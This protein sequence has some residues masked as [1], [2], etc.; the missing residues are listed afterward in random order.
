MTRPAPC[1]GVTG[2][3]DCRRSHA[4]DSE[5]VITLGC[6]FGHALWAHL[7]PTWNQDEEEELE[8]SWRRSNWGRKRLFTALKR[9]RHGVIPHRM[10][11]FYLKSLIDYNVISNNIL[12]PSLFYSVP[13]SIMTLS[14][15][16]EESLVRKLGW[17][18]S[19]K[20]QSNF[21]DLWECS[22]LLLR[23]KDSYLSVIG[24]FQPW[25]WTLLG[26]VPFLLWWSDSEGDFFYFIFFMKWIWLFL[27]WLKMCSLSI[28]NSRDILLLISSLL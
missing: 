4:G 24:R 28:S 14:R 6:L 2:W 25:L 15:Y 7:D 5:N 13:C 19:L 23:E 22:W 10:K 11:L 1:F 21:R 3:E 12:F 27:S 26:V 18:R 9:K 17:R 16:A 8:N 20:V